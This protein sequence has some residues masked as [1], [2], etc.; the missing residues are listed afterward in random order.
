MN[1]LRDADVW[2]I[3]DI[4]EPLPRVEPDRPPPDP[5]ELPRRRARKVR[6]LF[7]K[8]LPWYRIVEAYQAISF[9]AKGTSAIN[10]TAGTTCAPG[11]PAGLTNATSRMYMFISVSTDKTLSI[12]TPSGWTKNYA[13]ASSTGITHACYSKWFATGDTAPSVSWTTAAKNSGIILAYNGLDLTT[14]EDVVLNSTAAAV[15]STGSGID[16]SKVAA[17]MGVLRLH[18]LGKDGTQNATIDARMINRHRGVTSASSAAYLDVD[19]EAGLAAGAA[20]TRTSTFTSCNWVAATILL[21]P[22]TPSVTGII[23]SKQFTDASSNTTYSTSFPNSLSTG[24]TLV[25][26]VANFRSAGSTQGSVT[27]IAGTN[28][29]FTQVPTSVEAGST[30]YASTWVYQNNTNTTA[31]AVTVNI[32]GSASDI[33]LMMYEIAGLP[34]SGTLV[35]RAGAATAGSGT[36]VSVSTTA[37]TRSGPKIAFLFVGVAASQASYTAGGSYIH[38]GE[39]LSA[40]FMAFGA[41]SRE[42]TGGGTESATATLGTSS[43]WEGTLVVLNAQ[44][45]PSAPTS[46]PT[47]QVGSIRFTARWSAPGSG[48]TVDGYI[49]DVATSNL[50][51]VYVPGFQALDVGNVTSVLVTGLSP[52]ATYYYRVRAYNATGN[53]GN[54]GV[55]SQITEQYFHPF[56]LDNV[57]V[58]LRPDSFSPATNGAH[59]TNWGDWSAGG[60]T[61]TQGTDSKRPTV[62]TGITPKGASAAQFTPVSLQDLGLAAPNQMSSN[63]WSAFILAMPFQVASQ[64][65]IMTQGP[66]DGGGRQINQATDPSKI[67]LHQSNTAVVVE[68]TVTSMLANNWYVFCAVSAGGNSHKIYL[69]DVLQGTSTASITWANGNGLYIGSK[70]NDR[71]FSGLMVA[72][73]YYASALSDADK[74]S[75]Y[76]WMWDTYISG[77]HDDAAASS[78]ITLSTTTATPQVV[79]PAGASTTLT[80]STTTATPRVVVPAQASSTLTFTTTSPA[81]VVKPGAASSTITLTASAIGAVLDPATASTALTL[82]ASGVSSDIVPATA[83]TTITL[84]ATGVAITIGSGPTYQDAVASSTITLSATAVSGDLVPATSATTITLTAIAHG[85]VVKLAH[86]STTLTLTASAVS[87]DIVPASASTAIALTSTATP[88]VIVPATSATALSL[89]LIAHAYVVKTTATASTLITL[90]TLLAHTD[91]IVPA[92]AA[93]TVQLTAVGLGTIIRMAHASTLITINAVA[94]AD[95]GLILAQGSTVI[96]LTATAA[97]HVVVPAHAATSLSITSAASGNVLTMGHGSSAILLTAIAHA[98]GLRDAHASTGIALTASA[99]ASQVV[100]PAHASTLILISAVSGTTAFADARASTLIYFGTFGYPEVVVPAQA[101]STILITGRVQTYA[102]PIGHIYIEGSLGGLGALSGSIDGI[103]GIVGSISGP[104]D[105]SVSGSAGSAI[106]IIGSIPSEVKP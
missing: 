82:T 78:T 81:R 34:T 39:N 48:A 30:V 62:V 68:G 36:S 24:S 41:Q 10:S 98:D 23:Q 27:Y 5:D 67:G 4:P 71:F 37:A 101:S 33:S 99:A 105:L 77:H 3:P 25:V 89:S 63:A 72:V 87:S 73:V 74:T 85:T 49:I 26:Q 16:V 103:L 59:I 42:L 46:G 70:F 50:F 92:H 40:T 76:N 79:V 47:T 21:R 55:S 43:E 102:P 29:A 51:T 35:D 14:P 12:S 86:V 83:A 8:A 106:G 28:L 45:V 52:I 97:P 104:S 58:C 88:R 69:N 13:L 11:I 2:D 22:A 32:S 61:V 31:A 60:N 84:T 44:A 15:G 57:V 66:Y 54:S 56:D 18:A 96:T 93:T 7:D 75:V 94:S 17:T 19:E 1:A 95:E 20:G 9:V 90:N 80:I 65:A 64:V 38:R 100:V 91:D 53:S 6:E